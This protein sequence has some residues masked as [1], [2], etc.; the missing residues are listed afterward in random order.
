MSYDTYPTTP[1]PSFELKSSAEYS[2]LVSESQSQGEQRAMQNRFPRRTRTLLYQLLDIATEWYLIM[3]F[4]KGKRGGYTPFWYFEQKKRMATEEKVGRGDGA[5]TTFDLPSKTTDND[6][7]LK[8][9]VNGVEKT[10][11]THYNFVSGGGG[12]SSD[13]ITFTAGNIPTT[14]Q[15]ITADFNGYLRML[16]VMADKLSSVWYQDENEN[17]EAIALRE[18]PS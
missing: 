5:T 13:R 16:M 15:L 10:K 17:Y 18:V 6:A 4:F 3:D 1:S 8:V 2:T 14:G 9:Y 7:T 11:T 12:G